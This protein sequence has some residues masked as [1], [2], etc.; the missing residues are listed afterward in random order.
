MRRDVTVPA[1]VA[2]LA[3]DAD[4]L[5]LAVDGRARPSCTPMPQ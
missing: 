4:V 2:A 1:S 5:V 3:K